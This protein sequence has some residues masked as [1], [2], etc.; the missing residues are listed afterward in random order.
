MVLISELVWSVCVLH[1]SKQNMRSLVPAL[2]L[3]V[4]DSIMVLPANC[5]KSVFSH[6]GILAKNRI[7]QF[8]FDLRVSNIDGRY[9]RPDVS[10]QSSICTVSSLVLRY[11]VKS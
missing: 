6:P 1:N 5:Q 2:W 11:A 10:N 9:N 4:V 8:N 7:V 3:S